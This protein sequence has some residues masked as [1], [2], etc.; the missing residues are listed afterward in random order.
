[1]RDAIVIMEEGNCLY[2]RCPHCDMLVPQKALNGRYLATALCRQGMDRKWRRL[3]EYE[4]WEG[5]ERSLTAY[6]FPLYQ[7]ASFKYLGRVLAAEDN[8][9]PEVVHNLQKSS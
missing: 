9:W 3:A 4:V 8:N 7:V 5:T 2:P 1:M 6:G